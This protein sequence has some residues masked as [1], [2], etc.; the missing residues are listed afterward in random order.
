MGQVVALAVVEQLLQLY[1]RDVGQPLAQSCRNGVRGDGHLMS[2]W[3]AGVIVGE[4]HALI[5]LVHVSDRAP[6]VRHF[7]VP[8]CAEGG[9]PRSGTRPTASRSGSYL[10]CAG[11]QCIRTTVNVS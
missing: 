11:Y 2:V 6:W 9:C 7:V 4:R 3:Q 10:M 1:G 5:S 8:S